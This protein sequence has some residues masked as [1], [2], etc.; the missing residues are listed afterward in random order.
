MNKTLGETVIKSGLPNSRFCP[1]AIM[2]H[3]EVT[4]SGLKENG[5][6]LWILNICL[7]VVDLSMRNKIKKTHGM[8][9]NVWN[10]SYTS[11]QK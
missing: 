10:K 8:I 7:N 4:C 5:S 11:D 9:I 3:A 1:K 2:Q 6:I